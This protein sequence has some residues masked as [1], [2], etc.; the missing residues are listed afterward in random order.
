VKFDTHQDALHDEHVILWGRAAPRPIGVIRREAIEDLFPDRALSQKQVIQ[1]VYANENAI[2]DLLTA[3][4]E[5]GEAYRPRPDAP[6]QIDLSA[7]EL[8]ASRERL[9]DSILDAP[10]FGW[11]TFL[12]SS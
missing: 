10:A 9:R 11:G 5:A 1:F 6:P 12:A 8:W 2:G 4:L 3:K 7:A